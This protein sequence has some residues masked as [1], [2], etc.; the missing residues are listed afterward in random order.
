MFDGSLGTEWR[1]YSVTDD[2]ICSSSFIDFETSEIPTSFQ[3]FSGSSNAPGDPTNWI[4]EICDGTEDCEKYWLLNFYNFFLFLF[5][6][7]NFSPRPAEKTK[8]VSKHHIW[9]TFLPGPAHCISTR[10]EAIIP[11]KF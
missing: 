7:K 9:T 10:S 3:F 2:G 6:S 11:F 8:K 1:D 4:F 5:W